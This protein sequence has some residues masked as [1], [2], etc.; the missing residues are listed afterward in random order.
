MGRLCIKPPKLQHGL[1]HRRRFGLRQ[2]CDQYVVEKSET[3]GGCAPVSAGWRSTRP[4][5]AQRRQGPLEDADR[6][7]VRAVEQIVI[8]PVDQPEAVHREFERQI[9]HGD[10][11]C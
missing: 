9:A 6:R 3:F 4:R 8:E 1:T 7:P 5:P 2:Q 11:L 10:G